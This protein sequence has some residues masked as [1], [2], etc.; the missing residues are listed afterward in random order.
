MHAIRLLTLTLALGLTWAAAVAA[1]IGGHGLALPLTVVPLAGF[2]SKDEIIVGAWISDSWFG[3]P[4]AIIGLAAAFLTALYMFRL[5]FLVFFGEERFDTE[6][7]HPHESGPWMAIPL[8]GSAIRPFR[9]LGDGSL[10]HRWN[11]LGDGL[12]AALLCG[13]VAQ[14]L[15]QAMDLFAGQKTGLPEHANTV[16]LVVMAVLAH[17]VSDEELLVAVLAVQRLDLPLRL[18]DLSR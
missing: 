17:L 16:A 9:R 13:W 10:L 4:A 18:V 15:T 6:H 2:W 14:K 3:K 5:V 8:I 7:V 1:L 11:V 12:I